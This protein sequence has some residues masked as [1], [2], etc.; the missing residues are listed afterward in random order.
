[1]RLTTAILKKVASEMGAT[2]L[3]EPEAELIGHITFKNGKKTVFNNTRLNINGFGSS[4]LAQD[5]GFSNYF[6]HQLGYRVTEGKTFFN[7]K[8]CAKIPNPRNIYDGWD[9]AQELGLPVI[10]KP[11]NLSLGILVTKV[12]DKSEY[13]EVAEKI[14]N[15][16]PGLIVE[17]FYSGN[18]FRILAL[19]NQVIAAYQRI[20]L[21][22][23]GDG[24]STILQLLL[25]K[26][27][28]LLKTREKILIDV[29]DFRI[30]Q[31]LQ[32]QNLTCDSVLANNT[33]VY[34]LDNANLSSGGDSVDFTDTIH[35][36]FEK[37]AIN[38]TKDMGLR[39]A[40]VDIL[41]TDITQPL[42]DYT[43]LEINSA[44][45]L[46]HYAFLG[47]KQTQKVE[48]LYRLILQAL[49]KE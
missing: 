40:G 13:Y 20:P 15:I 7:E 49:E 4:H 35:P 18:D 2:V 12:Y 19:D 8:I 3:I 43:L 27:E 36:D 24:K 23:T 39:L 6:L 38:I 44:P 45:G 21:S 46:A 37:L 10:V 32:K 30:L 28:Q 34:L 41:T 9:Y 1:M 42:V 22:V 29:E 25:T 26:R 14:F 31:K 17:R 48:N 16:H 11:L 33:V 47:D 5:K